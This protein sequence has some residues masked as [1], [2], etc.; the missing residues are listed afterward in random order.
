MILWSRIVSSQNFF[1]VCQ[2]CHPA[3]I[4]EYISQRLKKSGLDGGV[5]DILAKTIVENTND[6]GVLPDDPSEDDYTSN[7]SVNSAQHVDDSQFNFVGTTSEENNTSPDSHLSATLS[8][9]NLKQN[10]V[11]SWP[12]YTN[13]VLHSSL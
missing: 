1:H 2:T 7:A 8:P 9:T 3:A 13:V 5:A 6:D 11:S 12:I 4:V 10:Q